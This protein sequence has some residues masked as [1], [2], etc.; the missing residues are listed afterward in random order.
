[1]HIARLRFTLKLFLRCH[2]SSLPFQ[3]VKE[4]V[5]KWSF[6]PPSQLQFP[7]THSPEEK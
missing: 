1:M 3:I 2:I 6:L 4:L 7:I 5:L